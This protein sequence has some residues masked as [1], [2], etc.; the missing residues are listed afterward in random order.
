MALTI[1]EQLDIFT[2]VVK[3]PS[4]SLNQYV[5]QAAIDACQN[6]FS[7]TKATSPEDGDAF[8]YKQKMTVMCTNIV[9]NVTR[10]TSNIT[11]VLL[12]IYA[13]T[14]TMAQVLAADDDGWITF[15]SNNM[16]SALEKLAGLS[17]QE[18]N[19]YDALP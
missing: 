17:A 5:E 19:A 8:I 12:A 13:D 16:F 9:G 3:P 11:R 18:K 15:I 14:G 10:Y 2:G 7:N 1:K 6:F 4:Y